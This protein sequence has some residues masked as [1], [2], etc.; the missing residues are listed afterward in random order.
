LDP[1]DTLDRVQRALGGEAVTPPVAGLS[2]VPP[3]ALPG[4]R[5]DAAASAARSIARTCEDARLDFAFVPSWEYWAETLVEELHERG[6]LAWWVADGLLWP[7]LEELGVEAGLRATVRAPES[8][9]GPMHAGLEIS[10][11]MVRR[12]LSLGVDGIVIAED[13]AGATGPIV[14]PDFIARE[15]MPSFELLIAP[16]R[17]AGVP[18]FL[19][20]DGDARV[21]MPGL[22]RAGFAA[23]HGDCGGAGGVSRALDAA[24][25]AGL[26]LVGGLPTS[27][28][29]NPGRA[30]AAG[31]GA[32]VLARAGG[33][34]L[35]DDGG[36]TT[37]D[38]CA[39]L[40]AAI[41]A[42]RRS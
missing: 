22:H 20:S 14:S 4:L 39:G 18:C 38:Q 21:F 19:H 26:S 16:A 7:A 12:G 28:L 13:L 1:D 8:L 41:A 35:A 34:L 23:I 40:L 31:T 36:I 11:S 24:A 32:G 10:R 29:G 25:T 5:A 37:S 17:S 15:V 42:A 27:D 3:A 9:K 30:I 2:F 33:L 6:V